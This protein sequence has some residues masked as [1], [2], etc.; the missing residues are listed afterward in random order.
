MPEDALF[1]EDFLDF[2]RAAIW[3]VQFGEEIRLLGYPSADGRGKVYVQP[4]SPLGIVAE[5]GNRE[6]AWAFLEY[7]ISLVCEQKDILTTSKSQLQEQME[8][9]TITDRQ[10]GDTERKSF[11][12]LDEVLEPVYGISREM[13]QQVMDLLKEADFS[14]DSRWKDDIAGIVLEEAEDFY[15]GNK[16]LEDVTEIIQNRAGILVQEQR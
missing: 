16:S 6:G 10:N 2:E 15:K 8:A 5:A 9:W 3:Q 1:I 13:A 7:Y 12:I 4:V 14:P 11:V